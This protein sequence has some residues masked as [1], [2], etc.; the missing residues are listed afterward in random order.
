[1]AITTVMVSLQAHI[2]CISEE[3]ATLSYV[4]TC[5]WENTELVSV[6]ARK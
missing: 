2:F 3:Q 6:S 5:H 4:N 1:M